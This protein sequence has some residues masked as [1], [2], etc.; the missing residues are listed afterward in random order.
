L[1]RSDETTVSDRRETAELVDDSAPATIQGAAAVVFVRR[2]A[3]LGI[4]HVGWG[5]LVRAGSSGTLSLVGDG[6]VWEIGAVENHHGWL[7]TPPLEDGYWR[8]RTHQPLVPVA[9]RNYDHYK[10][11]PVGVGNVE[12]AIRA[13][14]TVSER[15]YMAAVSNCMNDVYCILTAYGVRDL[16]NPEHIVNWIPNFWYDRIQAPEF[17]IA[18]ASGLADLSEF[19]RG[20][21]T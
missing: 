13:E 4:G 16:P 19:G 11:V 18:D 1:L 9:G 14:K 20:T 3:T 2:S 6:H 17:A 15:P 5:F 7:I 8:E 10:V 21:T 12:A